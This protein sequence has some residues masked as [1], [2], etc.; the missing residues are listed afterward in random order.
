MRTKEANT[1]ILLETRNYISSLAT[2]RYLS[3]L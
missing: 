3:L 1:H 2:S